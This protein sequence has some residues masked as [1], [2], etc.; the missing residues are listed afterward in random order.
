MMCN[1]HTRIIPD[2]SYLF[3]YNEDCM[4][5]SRKK[6]FRILK[7]AFLKSLTFRSLIIVSDSFI[8]YLITRSFTATISVIIFQIGRHYYLFSTRTIVEK[9]EVITLQSSRSDSY[10]GLR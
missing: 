6:W 7:R 4:T 2:G 8:I 3:R 1:L 5:A 9:S 10:P